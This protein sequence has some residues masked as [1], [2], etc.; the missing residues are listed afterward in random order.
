VKVITAVRGKIRPLKDSR[1]PRKIWKVRADDEDAHVAHHVRHQRLATLYH[2][3]HPRVRV[4][5]SLV[6][7]CTTTKAL[8]KAL[9]SLAVITPRPMLATD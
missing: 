6:C 5:G 4:A 8:P 7:T 3:R 9:T 1:A 2:F